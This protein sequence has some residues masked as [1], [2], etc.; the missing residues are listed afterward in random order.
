MRVDL[1]YGKTGLSVDLPD[2]ATILWPQELAGLPDE[3]AALRAALRAPLGSAPLVERLKPSDRVAIVFSDITRPMPNDRVLP[4]LLEEI[5]RVV[6][7]QQI[8]LINGTGTHQA[9]TPHE[10]IEMLGAKIAENYHII[11]HNAFDPTQL[12]EIGVTPQG[13]HAWVNRAFY[14]ADFKILTGFIEPHIFA[15]FS[16]GPKAVLPAV[17][18]IDS[19]MDNH[20]YTMLAH[21]RATW[22]IREGNPV[23][24]EIRDFARLTRPDFILNVTLNRRREITGIFAGDMEIAHAQGCA[25]VRETAMVPVEHRYEVVLTTNS[26]YPLDINL[27][28]TIKGISAAA[29]AVVPGGSIIV[30]SECRGGIPDY[31]EYRNLVMQ[32]GSADGILAMISQPGFRRH[33][34]WE[35]QLHANLLKVANIYVYSEGLTPQQIRDMLFYPIEDIQAAVR[36]ELERHGPGAR[37]LV[38]PEGPQSIPYLKG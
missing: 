34:Q 19:I 2:D 6:P 18:G 38:L 8:L 16:G 33:D 29:Q 28:Q 5:E 14:E 36:R 17:A 13:H 11:N 4:I 3:Q 37:L 23:W 30:A 21:P 20:S 15:G 32:G 35:A 25:L 26:G 31:G 9:N 12:T 22:G 27:Y 1:K 10:L 7:R 24:E